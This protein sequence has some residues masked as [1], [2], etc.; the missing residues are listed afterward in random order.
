MPIVLGDAVHVG[1]SAH[2]G[3]NSVV[4]QQVLIGSDAVIGMGSV[5]LGDV[6]ECVMAYGNPCKE[7]KKL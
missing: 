2:V 1:K 4:K 3:A 7:I 6:G 5:V